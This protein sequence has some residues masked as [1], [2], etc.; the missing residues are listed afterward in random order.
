MLEKYLKTIY[1]KYY[2]LNK[3]VISYRTCMKGKTNIEF[4]K[5]AFYYINHTKE[6]YVLVSDFSN[7]LIILNI[8][9]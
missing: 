3:S 6:C 9:Y 7:F 8:L 2:N 4:S 1:D 5:L